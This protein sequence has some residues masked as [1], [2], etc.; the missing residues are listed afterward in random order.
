LFW[1]KGK[2][3]RKEYPMV[4]VV[5]CIGARYELQDVEMGRVYKWC[6]AIVTVECGCGETL[7]YSSS[8]TTC[9]RCG[10]DHRDVINEVL[11]IGMEVDE[12]HFPWSHSPWRSLRAYFNRPESI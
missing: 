9:F 10:E 2:G 3:E 5:E 7:T 1:G 12:G 11:G 8:R 4:K 6:P